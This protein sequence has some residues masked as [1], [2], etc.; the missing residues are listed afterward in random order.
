MSLSIA[1]QRFDSEIPLKNPRQGSLMPKTGSIDAA[2]I[3]CIGQ[4]TLV[5]Q[6]MANLGK[7]N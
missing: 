4:Q 7:S 1:I 5:V 2:A 6:D 3:H